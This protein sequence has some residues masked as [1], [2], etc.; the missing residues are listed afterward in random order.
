MF[1]VLNFL[2]ITFFFF[3][4]FFFSHIFHLFGSNFI[5]EF[6]WR[7]GYEGIKSSIVCIYWILFSIWIL[8]Y[9][10]KYKLYKNDYKVLKWLWIILFWMIISTILSISIIGSVVWISEKFHWIFFFFSLIVFFLSVY[11]WFEKK[12]YKNLLNYIFIFSIWVYFYWFIQFI[13]HDS[14][15]IFY[16]TR[17][18][19]TRAS[20]FFWNANYLAWY[21]LMLLPLS[22]IISYKFLK[23]SFL[24]LSYIIL[25]LTWSY[26]WIFLWVLYFLYL[27]Y[28][29]N[30]KIFTISLVFFSISAAFIFNS[31]WIEKKW[32]LLAR[33]YI[34]ETSIIA[35]TDS[36]QTILFWY[37]PD[38]LQ[39]VFDKYKVAELSV[40][41]TSKYTADRT[42]NLFLDFIYFFGLFW[43]L[44]I[45]FF[46]IKPF[47]ISRNKDIK[48]SLLLF[49]LFFSFNVPVW[50]HFMLALF[51]LS[52][53]YNKNN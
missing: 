40:Y 35:I 52:W 5:L 34:W 30:K 26:F 53:V 31:I 37:W 7:G 39:L 23:L 51:L 8:I 33:P 45:I 36:P 4:I 9:L 27:I 41:E 2:V 11:F 1:W 13:W 14:L 20:S 44:L 32:S 12:D 19:I 48:L 42:H 18:I 6:S 46:I 24:L 25:F 15:S 21:I 28:N 38:T 43:W 16:E 10:S 50:I 49:I 47:K 17:V 3:V 29:Y 22:N